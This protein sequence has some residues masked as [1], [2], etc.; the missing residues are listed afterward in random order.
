VL[1]RLDALTGEP[2]LKP[3]LAELSGKFT[4]EAMRKMNA[5]VDVRHLQARDV[6]AEFLKQAGLR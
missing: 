1:T 4:N 3:A 2:R 6:A 5:D